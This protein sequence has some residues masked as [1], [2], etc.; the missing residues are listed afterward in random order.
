MRGSIRTYNDINIEKRKA[1]LKKVDLLSQIDMD[2]LTELAFQ[3]R[4]LRYSEGNLIA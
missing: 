3:V 4:P 1:L 2:A